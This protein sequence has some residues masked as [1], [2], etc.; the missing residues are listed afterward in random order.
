ME[1]PFGRRHA[2]LAQQ[3]TARSLDA[4]PAS[5]RLYRGG[6]APAERCGRIIAGM[7][8]HFDEPRRPA[9]QEGARREVTRQRV[10]DLVRN[11]TGLGGLSVQARHRDEVDSPAERRR[12]PAAQPGAWPATCHQPPGLQ[13]AST[14]S[15]ANI[16]PL[17]RPI[18]A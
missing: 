17:V 12:P 13:P 3:E 7:T 18:R 15:A 6:S 14:D 11:E 2:H 10:R 4:R 1:V 16:G 9:L 5:A 8:D